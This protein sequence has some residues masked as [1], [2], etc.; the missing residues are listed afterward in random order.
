MPVSGA[1][2]P[3]WVGVGGVHSLIVHLAK[4]ANLY[5]VVNSLQVKASTFLKQDRNKLRKYRT[6][7]WAGKVAEFLGG[8]V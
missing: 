6:L 1:S 8:A 3:T 4:E 7:N 5:R 2:G